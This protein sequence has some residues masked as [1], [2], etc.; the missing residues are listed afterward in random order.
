MINM[1][2]QEIL[3]KSVQK[4]IDGGWRGE[5]PDGSVALPHRTYYFESIPLNLIFNHEF[6]K[7]LWGERETRHMNQAF[8]TITKRGWRDHLQEMVVADDPIKYLGENI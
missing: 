1:A 2:T 3:E 4:A 7:A 5:L 8:E 6:A